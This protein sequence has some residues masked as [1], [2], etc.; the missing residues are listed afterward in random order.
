[1]F[2]LIFDENR[3]LYRCFCELKYDCGRVGCHRIKLTASSIIIHQSPRPQ[4]NKQ[5]DLRGCTSNSK[6][7]GY[8]GREFLVEMG[9]LMKCTTRLLFFLCDAKCKC[10]LHYKKDDLISCEFLVLIDHLCVFSRGT[11]V[12][13][14]QQQE[15]VHLCVPAAQPT[16]RHPHGVLGLPHKVQPMPTWAHLQ[17]G[18]RRR[19]LR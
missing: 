14:E 3:H 17:H 11:T 16:R 4:I 15:A 19:H 6:S 1:M 18:L 13:S 7:Q 5:Y 10:S 9:Q 12:T 2:H 8:C